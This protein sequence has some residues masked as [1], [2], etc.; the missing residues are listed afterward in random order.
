MAVRIDASGDYLRR[1][2]SLPSDTNS[3]I[4]GWAKLVSDRTG[5]WRYFCC[6]ENATTSASAYRLMGWNSSNEFNV[7]DGSGSTAFSAAPSNGDWFYFAL[8]CNG[9][10]TNAT[11]GYYIKL[12]GTV[13][14]AAQS[15]TSAF[16]EAVVY[17][18]S[19]S[20]DEWNN[21]SFAHVKIWDA[22]LTQAEL[23]QEMWSIVP[24]RY[25]NLHLWTPLFSHTD[26][27]DYS[28]NGRNWTGG[29]TLTTE[30]GP[31]V[32]WGS[33]IWVVPFVV[34]GGPSTLSV[35]VSDSVTVSE[36]V[37]LNKA[38]RSASVTDAV[39]VAEAKAVSIQ[40][41]TTRTVSVSDTATVGES[42]TAVLPDALAASATDSVT[43]SEAVAALLPDALA[44]TVTDTATASEEVT[45][46]ISTA[47]VSVSDAVSVA[48][49]VAASLPDA[50]AIMVSDTTTLDDAPVVTLIAVGALSVGVTDSATVSEEITASLADALFASV[51]DSITVDEVPSVS[52]GDVLPTLEIALNW[53]DISI[54]RQ[55]VKVVGP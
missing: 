25:T 53:W 20:Y 8:V 4:A 2:T 44:A 45:A 55:G 15:T 9:T 32:S 43:V 23:Q 27:V 41:A 14:T 26:L 31:P 28:G 22:V 3:T 1:T 29:G 5:Q 37:A 18:G 38:T 50:L 47:I 7:E 39:T 24:Q 34:A 48:E 13:Y 52:T 10:T 21:L 40:A 19:D 54:W 6:I 36:A 17:L 51:V 35:N 11:T 16:T 12:D 42:I 33:P 30:D 46:A 49:S